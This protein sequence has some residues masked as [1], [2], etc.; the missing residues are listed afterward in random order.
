MTGTRVRTAVTGDG[1]K[2]R[3]SDTGSGR[4]LLLMPG[5]CSSRTMF[6]ELVPRLAGRR[7]VLAVDWRGH[8]ESDPAPRDFGTDELVLDAMAVLD[9]AGV[10]EVVP[11]SASHAG[12]AAVGLRQRLRARVPRLV[13][14]SWMV[15]G[16]PPPFLAAL[17]GL[18][19]EESWQDV[20]A[21]LFEMWLNGSDS[22][23]ARRQVEDMASYGF[24]L[25]SRAGRAIAA[26]VAAHATPLDTLAAEPAP[27]PTLHLYAQPAVPE[28]LAAQQAFSTAHPWFQVRRIEGRT[29]FPMCE[30]PDALASEILAFTD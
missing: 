11:V 17:E 24:D 19:R 26:S 28:A 16:A 8:G 14:V 5:W 20:R 27:P 1:A 15:L 9:D 18:T 12:W 2:V 10:D 4:A 6:D 29:H 30:L 25:W 22:P 13:L 23:A 7:R 21:Q 3:Y